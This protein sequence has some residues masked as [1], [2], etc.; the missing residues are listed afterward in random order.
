MHLLC[1]QDEGDTG[2]QWCITHMPVGIPA[3]RSML[4]EISTRGVFCACYRFA[5]A[6]APRQDLISTALVQ[7][8]AHSSSSSS[9]Q[10]ACMHAIAKHKQVSAMCVQEICRWRRQGPRKGSL[11][12]PMARPA[13]QLEA[14]AQPQLAAPHCPGPAPKAPTCRCPL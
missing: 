1:L 14:G 7:A 10:A 9:R 3:Y 13:G 2:C 5:H 12:P 6:P 8:Q 4:D 11:V